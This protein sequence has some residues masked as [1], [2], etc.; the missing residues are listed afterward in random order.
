M[1]TTKLRDA[2][3]LFKRAIAGDSEINYTEGSIARVTL[4]L[5]IPMILEMAMESV[6]A[7][8]DIFFVAKLG[9]DAVASVGL[10]E[11]VITLLYALAIGLSMGATAMVA[12]RVGENNPDA[13]SIVAGQVIWLGVF[14]SVAVGLTGLFF[15]REILQLMGAEDSVVETGVGYTRL[16]IGGC[17]SIVLLFLINAIFRGAGDAA[18]AMRALWLANGINIVL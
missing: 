9:T 12:R 18:I 5:A 1:T 2:W 3:H 7:I 10:T 6:F 14:V 13:A 4:L 17:F 16:M 11:A 8:V 15:A